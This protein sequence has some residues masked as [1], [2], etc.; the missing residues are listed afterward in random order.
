M[1]T[2]VVTGNAPC[3]T[4]GAHVWNIWANS[5]TRKDDETGYWLDVISPR[6]CPYCGKPLN[7]IHIPNPSYLPADILQEVERV[8][9]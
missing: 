7:Y 8:T 1:T 4:C 9:R 5:D 6:S 3:S 2:K